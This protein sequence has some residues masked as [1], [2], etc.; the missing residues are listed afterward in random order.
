MPPGVRNLV[1]L[2]QMSQN[3]DSPEEGEVEQTP[4]RRPGMPKSISTCMILGEKYYG[5]GVY[6]KA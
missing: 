4:K 5:G 1:R 3:G 6:F 2:R